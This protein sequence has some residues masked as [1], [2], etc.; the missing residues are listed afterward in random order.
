MEGSEGIRDAV[1]R[2]EEVPTGLEKLDA[3]LA[4]EESKFDAADK[5]R[6]FDGEP[7]ENGN[8]PMRESS[9]GAAVALNPILPVWANIDSTG[10]VLESK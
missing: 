1:K 8:A 7:R 6:E 2:W 10:P 9:S 4:A 5:S 3:S